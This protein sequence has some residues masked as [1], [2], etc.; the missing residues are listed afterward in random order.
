MPRPDNLRQLLLA[1]L[2]LTASCRWVGEHVQTNRTPQDYYL[3]EGFIGW[4]KVEYESPGSSPLPEQNG[5][6]IL[7]F[8]RDGV[9]RTSSRLQEGW[10]H[11]RYFYSSPQQ[12]RELRVTGWNEGG[13]IW[14]SFVRN[15]K[16]E[17]FF[18]GSQNDYYK[19]VNDPRAKS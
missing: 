14:A 7:R 16:T 11:D 9:L 3:P 13:S 4:A 15:G 5:R 8:D 6:R 19:A 1:L 2:L 17:E 12:T 18:V 10:A